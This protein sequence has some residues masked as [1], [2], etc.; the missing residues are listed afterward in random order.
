MCVPVA[1]RGT[2]HGWDSRVAQLQWIKEERLQELSPEAR[3]AEVESQPREATSWRPP[4]AL[5]AL[6]LRW[7][8]V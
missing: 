2:H 7:R 4:P 8:S 5:A 3:I 1:S 6:P